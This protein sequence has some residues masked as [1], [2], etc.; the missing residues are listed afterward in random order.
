VS[1][2]KV[3]TEKQ[4]RLKKKTANT[5]EKTANSFLERIAR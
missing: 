1:F 2:R 4:R 5:K 3:E